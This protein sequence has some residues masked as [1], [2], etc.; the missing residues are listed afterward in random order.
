[1]INYIKIR[2]LCA[3]YELTVDVQYSSTGNKGQNAYKGQNA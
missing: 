2:I 1:M 3:N